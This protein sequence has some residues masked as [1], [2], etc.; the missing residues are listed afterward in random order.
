MSGHFAGCLTD[1][2]GVN[3][4]MAEAIVYTTPT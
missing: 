4:K 2:R 3:L 1:K